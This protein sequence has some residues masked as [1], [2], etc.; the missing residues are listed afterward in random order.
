MIFCFNITE[1]D[2]YELYLKKALRNFILYMQDELD[3]KKNGIR[4]P[5]L[6]VGLQKDQMMNSQ[7]SK[8][9]VSELVRV[10]KEHFPCELLFVSHEDQHDISTMVDLLL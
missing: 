3:Q 1:K 9:D 2:S 7:V 5:I 8:E 6:I 10:L 4:I